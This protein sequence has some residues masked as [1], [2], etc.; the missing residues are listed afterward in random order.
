MFS[1]PG[2]GSM[3]HSLLHQR[4]VT[5][6][7][8]AKSIHTDA[9][10]VRKWLAGS[11]V[12]SLRSDYHDRICE[13]LNLASHEK[14][15]LKD[16][17]IF[18]LDPRN[19][20][21]AAEAKA[22]Q[23]ELLLSLLFKNSNDAILFVSPSDGAILSANPAAFSLCQVN[24]DN[25]S[26]IGSAISVCPESLSFSDYLQLLMK[27]KK[28]N[29]CC[30]LLINNKIYPVD[31]NLQVCD[32]V[33]QAGF[34]LCLMHEITEPGLLEKISVFS[35]NRALLAEQK[36]DAIMSSISDGFFLLDNNWVVTFAN[37]ALLSNPLAA[38]FVGKNIIED[39][40]RVKEFHESFLNVKKTK[41]SERRTAYIPF[42]K[43][44][45]ELNIHPLSDDGMA[46]YVRQVTGPSQGSANAL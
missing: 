10:L 32:P 17:Q 26:T 42:A 39:F 41:E 43:V 11:R 25:F 13:Y 14:Q 19:A 23:S 9:S 27:Q 29:A 15:L 18:S 4:K 3:L 21:K 46:V 16:S 44:W 34:V 5:P 8:L 22:R 12:P 40:P 20:L 1:S 24:A 37:R 28:S 7:D 36:F 33:G 30:K 6:A 2:F 45:I 38:D 31:I 35:Q